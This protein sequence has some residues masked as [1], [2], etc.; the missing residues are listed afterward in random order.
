MNRLRN[1]QAQ[2]RGAAR[3]W[4]IAGLLIAAGMG[5]CYGFGAYHNRWFPYETIRGLAGDAQSDDTRNAQPGR[6]GYSIFESDGSEMDPEMEKHLASMGT[7]GYAP[8][9][10]AAPDDTGVMHHEAER[11][12]GGLNLYTSGH[13]PE[14]ILMDMDGQVMHRWRRS[15]DEIWDEAP[16]KDHGISDYFEYAHLMPNGDLIVI[17]DDVGVFRIDKASNLIWANRVRGHHDL[18]VLADGRIA[19]LTRHS[20][21]HDDLREGKTVL[22][23]FVTLLDPDSGRVLGEV[24]LVAALRKSPYA[25]V[26]HRVARQVDV[27][28]ANTIELL[29]GRLADRLPAFAAGRLLVGLRDAN[30]IGVLDLDRESIVWA[31][32]DMGHGQHRPTALDNGHILVFD[33]LGPGKERSRVVEFDPVTG[34]VAWEY[35]GDSVNKLFSHYYGGSSRL[36]NGNT[37]IV[38]SEAGRVFEV[39]ANG[40]IVWDFLNP[41][42]AGDNDDLIAT[43]FHMERLGPDAL[44]HWLDVG[45]G[46]APAADGN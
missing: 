11:V 29:D 28:H 3:L 39:M 46:S 34:A 20:A 26:L 6:W 37:L 32:V 19:V 16:P 21:R 15:Y 44:R 13:A 36:A 38:Q 12:Q 23:D 2:Q 27:L 40:R 31:N 1:G 43:I 22:E 9:Y 35:V 18:D 45:G 41:A 10:H 33:N 4:V 42:R 25:G 14:A 24:S 30:L 7:A 8:G 5:F 17:F